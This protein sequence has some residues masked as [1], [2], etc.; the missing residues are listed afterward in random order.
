MVTAVTLDLATVHS[1]RHL[2]LAGSEVRMRVE[3][4]RLN[5]LY[6]LRVEDSVRLYAA[7]SV[8]SVKLFDLDDSCAS[9]EVQIDPQVFIQSLTTSHWRLAI[10]LA[11]V[12]KRIV[13]NFDFKEQPLQKNDA[14]L[15]LITKA[16][17][18]H[19]T[20]VAVT[21]HTLLDS[22]HH[23][24]ESLCSSVVSNRICVQTEDGGDVRLAVLHA[25]CKFGD[26]ELLRSFISEI[27][28]LD[29]LIGSAMHPLFSAATSSSGA[30]KILADRGCNVNITHRGRRPLQIAV[31]LL[32][33]SEG[34][35]GAR[36]RSIGCIETLIDLDAQ[37]TDD[38]IMKAQE[39]HEDR[40]VQ[41]LQARQSLQKEKDQA[42]MEVSA[43]TSVP[44]MSSSTGLQ[45]SISPDPQVCA[46]FVNGLCLNPSC[47]NVHA[48]VVICCGEFFRSGMCAA[49]SACP[50][51]HAVP[52]QL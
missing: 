22:L 17:I 38:V 51:Q 31:E 37:V 30:I 1:L 27:D 40:I 13:C 48:D 5:Q 12:A 18:S 35:P 44:T 33:N 28:D 39:A 32:V 15:H 26:S 7:R 4:D 6:S 45:S 21:E 36:S 50:F 52:S 14:I 49:G 43:S 2:T 29:E 16:A 8:K 24:D 9:V 42:D 11:D 3:L 46:D 19:R 34:D 20:L 23:V 10:Q 47:R 41:K 25:M